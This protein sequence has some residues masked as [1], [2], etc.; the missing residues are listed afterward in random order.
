MAG[1]NNVRRSI[2]A[3]GGTTP[4]FH[5]MDGGGSCANGLKRRRNECLYRGEPTRYERGWV[6]EVLEAGE[7][8]GV[9]TRKVVITSMKADRFPK[10]KILL[11]SR[12][13]CLGHPLNAYN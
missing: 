1:A 4:E 13:S 6:V 12:C 9:I 2:H 10:A 8:R 5:R 3:D 11:I 7:E